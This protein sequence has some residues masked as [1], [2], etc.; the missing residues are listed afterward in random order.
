MLP[1]D[2]I[3]RLQA[4]VGAENIRLPDPRFLQVHYTLAEIFHTSGMGESID[5]LIREFEQTGCF[6]EDGSTDVVQLLT[7]QLASAVVS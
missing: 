7:V 3:V 4:A 6:A 5:R 1:P 2:R